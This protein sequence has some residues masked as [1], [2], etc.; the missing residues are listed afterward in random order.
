MN[1]F[2]PT[3]VEKSE[4]R[5]DLSR[6]AG[7]ALQS[8]PSPQKSSSTN[9]RT[10]WLDCLSPILDSISSLSIVVLLYMVYKNWTKLL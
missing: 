10:T 3:Q 8:Q 7:A 4:N 6:D 1:N 2:R 9:K 5:F